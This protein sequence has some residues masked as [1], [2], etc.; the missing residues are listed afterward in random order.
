M[1]AIVCDSATATEAP[2]GCRVIAFPLVAESSLEELR[3]YEKFLMDPLAHS[4]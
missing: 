3:R 2:K 4:L 1:A